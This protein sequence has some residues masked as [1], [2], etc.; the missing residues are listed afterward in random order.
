MTLLA[1]L[2][3]PRIM[4]HP[5][6]KNRR[7]KID[8]FF[9]EQYFTFSCLS[10][11]QKNIRVKFWPIFMIYKYVCIKE[12]RE[13]W[14]QILLKI[15]EKSLVKIRFSCFFPMQISHFS[16][17]VRKSL[18]PFE[19]SKSRINHFEGIIK[20][21]SGPVFLCFCHFARGFF[22]SAW[23]FVYPAKAS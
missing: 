15:E 11:T 22:C 17:M 13:L 9:C 19:H 16:F 1:S 3:P 10:L 2:A 6:A 4:G 20:V 8:R 18:S 12:G 21:K 7:K 23:G 5:V 14:I